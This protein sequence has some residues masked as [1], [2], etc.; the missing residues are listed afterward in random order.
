MCVYH[1]QKLLG[2]LEEQNVDSFTDAVK[3][4]DSISRLDQ[5]YTSMLL[6][7]KKGIEGEGEMDLR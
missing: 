1:L 7:I 2:A 4:Y 3:E 5:W 6:R